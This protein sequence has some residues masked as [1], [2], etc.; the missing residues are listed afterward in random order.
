MGSINSPINKW[1]KKEK[2]SLKAEG[3]E[4]SKNEIAFKIRIIEHNSIV[5]D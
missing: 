1:A 5:L 2:W 4:I 3:A